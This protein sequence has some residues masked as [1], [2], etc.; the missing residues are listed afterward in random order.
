MRTK[1]PLKYETGNQM[2]SSLTG[3]RFVNTLKMDETPKF[4]DF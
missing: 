1:K 2:E 3:F 4:I